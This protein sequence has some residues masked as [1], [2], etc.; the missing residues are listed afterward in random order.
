MEQG[1]LTLERFFPESP[2]LV[3]MDTE[4]PIKHRRKYL[5]SRL[6][7]KRRRFGLTNSKR[8]NWGD[9]Q[10]TGYMSFAGH[11]YSNDLIY[12]LSAAIPA[13]TLE[14]G[15]T[16]FAAVADAVGTHCSQVKPYKACGQLDGYKD[17]L[18]GRAALLTQQ[19]HHDPRFAEGEKLRSHLDQFGLR[20]PL[21]NCY[22]RT[23][24]LHRAQPLELGWLNYWSAETCEYIGFPDPNRD[25]DLLK[26]SYQTP[27][28]AW[29]VKL[30]P[31]PLDLDRDDHL[32]MFVSVYER[33]PKLG[34]R[35]AKVEPPPPFRYPEHTTYLHHGDPGHIAEQLTRLLE[36]HGFQS[37]PSATGAAGSDA[38]TL[39]LFRG[40]GD[41]TI[42][43]T[44]PPEFLTKPLPGQ[45]EP[46]L[47]ELCREL[48][49]AGFCLNVYTEL[50]AALLEVAGTGRVSRSGIANF[51]ELP[52]DVDFEAMEEGGHPP[53]IQF[54]WLN[55]GVETGVG[56]FDDYG[57]IARQIRALLGGSNAD[58]CEDH[59]FAEAIK[60][61]TLQERQGIAL[62]YW[63][64]G[65]P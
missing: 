58:L 45:T 65:P 46:V 16:V 41:W 55:P 42:I 53:L 32:R 62:R 51:A 59:Q 43:K 49:R 61:T 9:I 28:G 11:T 18:S 26:Y 1:C 35:E 5:Q 3:D 31:E 6:K 10:A 48:R 37:I 44:Q 8:F 34:L 29:L 64:S 20:L 27:G 24:H 33:F 39:G 60:G 13:T 22:P 25:R 50:E 63:R 14:I 30:C 56:D 38:V 21:I 2:L 40:F 23:P 54:R 12:R 57:Q 47:V 4:R 17:L 36:A 52:E 19:N 7:T 15:E